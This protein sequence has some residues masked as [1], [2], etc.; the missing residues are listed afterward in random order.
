MKEGEAGNRVST[1]ATTFLS[2]G[3][4]HHAIYLK[5]KQSSEYGKML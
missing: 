1:V 2:V 3:V 4:K 5:Y